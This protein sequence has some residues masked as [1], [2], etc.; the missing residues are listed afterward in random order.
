MRN[1]ARVWQ[2]AL[3]GLIAAGLLAEAAFTLIG[4]CSVFIPLAGLLAAGTVYAADHRLS[5]GR[6]ASAAV[7]TVIG[8]SSGV[9]TGLF[10]LT[11]LF[12]L[13]VIALYITLAL[14]YVLLI[15]GTRF[16]MQDHPW[17]RVLLI[18][19]GWG[20]VPLILRGIPLTAAT[21]G[22]VAGTA[23]LF[24][25]S[26]FWSDMHDQEEDQARGRITPVQLLSPTGT[27]GWI[28]S[29]YLMSILGYV[30]GGMPLLILPACAGLASIALDRS[31]WLIRHS[32]LF[33]LWPGVLAVT[34]VLGT[35]LEIPSLL[36]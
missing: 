13:A 31:H 2:D 3:P 11:D 15:P 32:D 17:T 26:V 16:R 10:L 27:R 8:L 28:I 21:A 29:G 9:L 7:W 14:G 35:L 12:R 4:T 34:R 30:L 36:P 20:C 5:P 24:L 6:P 19:L 22:F 25:S 1:S 18:A 33:L 23:G